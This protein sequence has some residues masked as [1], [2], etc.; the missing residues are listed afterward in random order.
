M[1]AGLVVPVVAQPRAKLFVL[2][3]H[4]V[5]YA[6]DSLLV[7]TVKWSLLKP[8]IRLEQTAV[9]PTVRSVVTA[10]FKSYTTKLAI[11]VLTSVP[12]IAAKTARSVEMVSPTP[13][14]SATT[15]MP[16]TSMLAVTTVCYR[17]AA[18]AFRISTNS[19]MMAIKMTL[20]RATTTAH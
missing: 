9:V 14:R 6:K 15:A 10:L 19:A 13:L 4:C 12:V 5:L 1:A 11:S 17:V 2:A 3:Q 20:M 8:A 16:I 18:T 7:A